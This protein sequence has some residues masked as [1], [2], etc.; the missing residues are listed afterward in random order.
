MGDSHTA[1]I[2][3]KLSQITDFEI[4]TLNNTGCYY[5]PN[6]SLFNLDTKVEYERCNSYTQS[7]RTKK[8]N[9]LKKLHNY[10]RRQIAFIFKWKKFDNLEGGIEGGRFKD[11][12]QKNLDVNL[13]D[14]IAKPILNLANKNKVIILYPIPELGWDIKRKILKNTSRN[15]LKIKDEFKKIFQ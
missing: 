6:F 9:S 10:N 2:A 3:T 8:L 13:R 7:E 15:I 11:L 14:E 1:I 12:K 5:L 4:I